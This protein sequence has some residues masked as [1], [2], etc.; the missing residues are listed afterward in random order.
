MHKNHKDLD[1]LP[2]SLI[3]QSFILI[4]KEWSTLFESWRSPLH[5]TVKLV[6]KYVEKEGCLILVQGAGMG[7]LLYELVTQISPTPAKI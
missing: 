4:S 3:L 2:P 7:R 5:K 1:F 6:K